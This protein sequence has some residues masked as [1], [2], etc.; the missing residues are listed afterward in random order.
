MLVDPAPIAQT[1]QHGI[2]PLR[3]PGSSCLQGKINMDG[4]G[5]VQT[6][7]EVLLG[8]TGFVLAAAS[9]MIDSFQI[10]AVTFELHLFLLYLTIYDLLLSIWLGN[11]SRCNPSQW[12]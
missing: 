9:S 4:N 5:M 11:E 1:L 2:L 6:G 8:Q 7:S 10:I 12:F 3:R